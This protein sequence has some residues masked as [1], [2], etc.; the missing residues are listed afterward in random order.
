MFVVQCTP[1]LI[2]I[3]FA[4]AVNV[5][6]VI[7]IACC[8]L[9]VTVQ[10]HL[11]FT[12]KAVMASRR[13]G[14]VSTKAINDLAIDMFWIYACMRTFTD[15]CHMW[16]GWV[17]LDI[18]IDAILVSK[19]AGTHEILHG[20]GLTV[21]THARPRLIKTRFP[22]LKFNSENHGGNALYIY[23]FPFAFWSEMGMFHEGCFP[24]RC[25]HTEMSPNNAKH[26]T[27]ILVA[28][29][30]AGRVGRSRVHKFKRHPTRPPH[31]TWGG[32]RETHI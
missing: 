21:Y 2:C 29:L 4:T 28:F 24:P 7:L 18:T 5:L 1:F 22:I 11:A 3:F 20:N 16:A 31:T 30:L 9:W 6:I 23:L 12:W 32:R 25:E 17:L 19:W 10:V 13:A 26:R 15:A 27:D 14:R 8:A